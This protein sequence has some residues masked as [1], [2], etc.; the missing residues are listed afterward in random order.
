MFYSSLRISNLRPIQM[1]II[2]DKTRAKAQ[3]LCNN[4]GQNTVETRVKGMS[5]H[6]KLT[7][8]ST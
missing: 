5:K 1:C 8:P 3:K 4:L 6:L 7:G 2:E